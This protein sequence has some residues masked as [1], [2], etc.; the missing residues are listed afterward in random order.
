MTKI[1]KIALDKLRGHLDDLQDRIK[2]DEIESATNIEG[3]KHKIFFAQSDLTKAF[4][5]IRAI[6]EANPE[7]Y[8]R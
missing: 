1:E 2:K 7:L 5:T 3:L 8:K 4:D 6:E